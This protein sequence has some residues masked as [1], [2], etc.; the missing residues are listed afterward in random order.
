M[1]AAL[2]QL[3]EHARQFPDG[4][5]APERRAARILIL[6]DAGETSRAR[7]LAKT[8]LREQAASPLAARIRA[9]CA[10]Q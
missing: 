8:F 7:A 9:A 2:A 3:D 1:S 6:C 5:L 4:A 10:G